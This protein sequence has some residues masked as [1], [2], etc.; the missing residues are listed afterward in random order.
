MG[1]CFL[2]VGYN[3][4]LAG[5]TDICKLGVLKLTRNP[6]DLGHWARPQKG[7]ELEPRPIKIIYLDVLTIAN[8]FEPFDKVKPTR[9]TVLLIGAKEL[10]RPVTPAVDVVNKSPSWY[11]YPCN[12]ILF[13]F[14]FVVVNCGEQFSMTYSGQYL[15][16]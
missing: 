11:V 4:I 5:A 13:S 2:L 1:A 16:V 9:V 10:M 8:R 7:R 3:I 12:V 14:S 6:C 15:V